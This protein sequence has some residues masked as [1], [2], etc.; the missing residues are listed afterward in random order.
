MPYL[1]RKWP[2]HVNLL[3]LG[4]DAWAGGGAGGVAAS[5]WWRSRM[6]CKRLMSWGRISECYYILASYAATLKT[7]AWEAL[8]RACRK[9]VHWH[10][11]KSRPRIWR[12]QSG[13][14]IECW[15]G[16]ELEGSPVIRSWDGCGSTG[17]CSR[18]SFNLLSQI[19]H[20]ALE[21]LNPCKIIS[22]V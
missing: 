20:F 5:V 12:L 9:T 18:S 6:L 10:C 13:K 8:S 16:E 22:P 15:R 7:V 2:N 19:I 17:R 21:L 3:Y 11:I 1:I 4:I 14:G